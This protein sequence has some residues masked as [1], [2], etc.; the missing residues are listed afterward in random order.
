MVFFLLSIL[1]NY[2][3]VQVDV[4]G[5]VQGGKP[6]DVQSGVLSAVEGGVKGDG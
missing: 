1:K 2:D 4:L 6:G 5:G 3:E